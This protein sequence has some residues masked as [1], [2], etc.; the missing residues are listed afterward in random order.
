MNT[1]VAALRRGGLEHADV[2]VVIDGARC[3]SGTVGELMADAA[4]VAGSLQSLGVDPG[5][6]VGVMMPGHREGLVAQAAVGLTGATLLPIITTA[7]PAEAGDLLRRSG[8]AALLVADRLRHRDVADVLA[9]AGELPELRTVVVAGDDGPGSAA[10]VAAA[11]PGPDVMAWPDLPAGRYVEPDVAADDRAV[12]VYTSGTTAAPKGV[13]HTH[14]SLLAETAAP[15]LEPD[16]GAAACQL[17]VFP[18]GHVAGLLGVLRLLVQGTAAVIMDAWN[19]ARAAALIDRYAVTSS[20]GAPIHLAG[21]LDERDR[22]A[23]TLASLREYMVGA[24]GVPVSL[25]ER[26]EAAGVLAYRCYGSSEHPTITSGCAADPTDKRARTDGRP[27]PG[28]ELRLLDPEGADVPVGAH[29]E[30]VCRGP[31]LFVGYTDPAV[32]ASAFTADGW[33]RTG[34]VGHVDADGYLTVT[35][36]IK[37]IIVRGGENLS[38]GEIEDILL[39][40]PAITEA[41]AV[42]VPDERYGERVCAVVVAHEPV[43]L[44]AVAAHFAASGVARQ[45]TPERLVMVDALPRTAAGKI[46]K[47]VLREQFI[48]REESS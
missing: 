25:I 4:G 22:G 29:G 12:L 30:I 35:D 3:W 47:H 43:D 21:L 10:A 17:S 23:A 42:G 1:L 31:E 24:A 39:R 28:T 14:A 44:D 13:Q 40:H 34:D 32:T 5:A 7:G 46:R 6:T 8:A 19:A 36:R 45:K 33:F 16:A 48:V 38:S 2:R 20:V 41:A 9:A 26:A 27:T 11:L 18:T 15:L 37:D